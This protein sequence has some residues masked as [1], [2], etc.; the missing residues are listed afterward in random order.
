MQI[1]FKFYRSS[2][3]VLNNQN[4]DNNGDVYDSKFFVTYTKYQTSWIW[5]GIHDNIVTIQ[6]S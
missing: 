3:R 6:W 4:N 2:Q 1:E 5:S